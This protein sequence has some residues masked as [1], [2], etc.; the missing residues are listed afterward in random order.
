MC[1]LD[2]A[3]Y[4]YTSTVLIKVFLVLHTYARE[5]EHVM[6][7]C[8]NAADGS[9]LYHSSTWWEHQ[10]DF[11]SLP[12]GGMGWEESSMSFFICKAKFLCHLY[13]KRTWVSQIAAGEDTVAR[14]FSQLKREGWKVFLNLILPFVSSFQHLV[15][16]YTQ[17]HIVV[18]TGEKN[19]RKKGYKTRYSD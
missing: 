7:K 6:L 1:L 3:P 18:G 13:R 8:G 17:W 12:Q 10:Q 11:T 5:C 4:A 2:S 14:A 9:Y 15:L 19:S 16:D